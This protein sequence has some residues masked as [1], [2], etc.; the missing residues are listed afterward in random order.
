MEESLELSS[1]PT[2]V[3]I[4]NNQMTLGALEKLKELNIK[5]PEEISLVGFDYSDWMRVVSPKLTSVIQQSYNMGERAAKRF[6]KRQKSIDENGKDLSPK[7]I[8]LPPEIVKG[9]STKEISSK[10]GGLAN[11]ENY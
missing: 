11:G 1:P 5:V 7:N 8:L 2:S 9:L 10:K 3:F 4:S 6:L